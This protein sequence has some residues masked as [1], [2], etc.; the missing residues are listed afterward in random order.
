MPGPDRKPGPPPAGSISATVAILLGIIA[1]GGLST[2]TVSGNL[3]DAAVGA[4]SRQTPGLLT[5]AA[6]PTR[7]LRTRTGL[8]PSA[9]LGRARVCP[10]PATGEAPA[11]AAPLHV[12]VVK[13]AGNAG[14]PGQDVVFLGDS[15][16]SGWRGVGEGADGWPAILGAAR[17]WHVHDLAVAGTGYVYPGWTAPIGSQVGAAIG[18]KPGVVFVAGGHNDEELAPSRAAV[19]ADLVLDRLRAGLPHAVIV[20]IGPIWPQGDRYRP[21]L[22]TLRNHLRAKAAAIGALFIDPIAAS[23]LAGANARYIG[24][25]G[26][27]PTASGYRRIARLVGASLQRDPRLATSHVVT[28]AVPVRPP[29]PARPAALPRMKL[30]IMTACGA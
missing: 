16:T 6:V 26:T 21:A 27:H 7:T 14:R 30:G 8:L 1:L 13:P 15:Y 10:Q 3:S 28:V 25:D 17:G 22:V 29:A 24:P 12:K 20:V 5:G 4:G 11:P 19:A 18:L 9:A 2:L 23:W